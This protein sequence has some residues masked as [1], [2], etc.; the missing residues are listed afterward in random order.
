MT[1]YVYRLYDADDV[2]L[3]VGCT[4]DVTKRLAHHSVY[5][6]WGHRIAYHLVEEWGSRPDAL[7]A[8]AIYIDALRPRYNI[9]GR[10]P[11]S[12]WGQ[13]DYAEYLEAIVNY[14]SPD[15][16]RRR[17]RRE[18]FDRRVARIAAEFSRIFPDTAAV[19]LPALGIAERAA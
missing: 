8:E 13:C 17:D 11:R 3:Y 5:Q 1:A 18:L 2:C 16:E 7:A 9:Y 6:P 10:G 14:P 12:C 15:R 19:V 4:E